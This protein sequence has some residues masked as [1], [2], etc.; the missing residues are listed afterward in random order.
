MPELIAQYQATAKWCR[1]QY[2]SMTNK[3]GPQYYA[4][5]MCEYE[6]EPGLTSSSVT[7]GRRWACNTCFNF[8]PPIW[9]DNEDKCPTTEE[10]PIEY[11]QWLAKDINAKKPWTKGLMGNDVR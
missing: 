2:K 9:T 7:K 6:D 1:H 8:A 3:R 10:A 5:T 11:G 4:V